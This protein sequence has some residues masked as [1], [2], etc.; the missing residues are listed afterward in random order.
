MDPMPVDAGTDPTSW[1][2]IGGSGFC[3]NIAVRL[4]YGD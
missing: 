4:R 2:G 1:N 3:T